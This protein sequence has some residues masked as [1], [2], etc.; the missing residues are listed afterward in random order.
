[1]SDLAALSAGELLARLDA[2]QATA[3]EAV[4]AHLARI[5]ARDGELGAYLCLNPRALEHAAASDDRRAGGAAGCLEGLPVAIKDNL[6]VAG[7][8]TTC[9][10][11]ILGGFLPPRDAT[12]VALLRRAG[13]VV[14]GKTNM[15]EFGMGSSTEHSAFKPARN[16]WDLA[17]VPGGSSGGSA[18]AVAAGLAPAAL[19]SDTGG[20]IRQPAAL[21]GVI[22]LK[23]TYGR[24]SRSGLVAF[25]SSLDQ[26]GP[27][28]RSVHDA[29]RLFAP[30]A[31]HDPLDASS[32][33]RPPEDWSAACA[34]GVDGLRIGLPREYFADG[35]DPE[36]DAAVRAAAEALAA[37][38]ARVDWVSLP[39]TR[40]SVPAYYLLAT[41]EAA[42]NL[43]RYDGVRFGRREVDCG[44]WPDLLAATR[45]R[46]F[47]AE[48]KRRIM[49][50]TFALATGYHA[51]FYGRAARARALV[52]QD[53]LRV[54][55]AGT[56]ALLAP[57][58][59]TA[60]FRL[61]EKLDDPLAMYLS[62]VYT[63]TANLAGLPALAVPAG[64]T[65]AGLPAGCQ[66]IGPPFGEA[67][68]FAAGGCLER[69]FPARV[70][71]EP[72]R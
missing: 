32:S 22:G 25:G 17:R 56:D 49:L 24:V 69:S 2:G 63:T 52:R 7:L 20:S 19:G 23:P 62:D 21:C 48:V 71:P 6:H 36:I 42:S 54:F 51:R 1:M 16:P 45:A 66:L 58:T 34:D 53:F 12:A 46:G 29:A 50:G 26:V 70:A 18:V 64:F 47:G 40:H 9:A 28:C 59:P 35:L 33:A 60:A 38:G 14:L 13:A 61:G 68:L 5:E 27:I 31:V 43:A 4:T 8:E 55:A 11:R 37:G 10:S 67:R 44:S 57:V 65:R 3:V 15:D 39:H 72:A 41:A 30:L